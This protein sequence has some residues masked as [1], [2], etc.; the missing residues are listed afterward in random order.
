[1]VKI[2]NVYSTNSY[3]LLQIGYFILDT[4]MHYIWKIYTQWII[5]T[6]FY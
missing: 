1:M 3:K 4:Y 2:I 6:L 5:L